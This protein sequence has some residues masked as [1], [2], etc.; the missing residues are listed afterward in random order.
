MLNH[1]SRIIILSSFIA[2]CTAEWKIPDDYVL[3]CEQDADCPGEQTC[4]LESSSCVDPNQPICGNGVTEFGE[5]CDA[6]QY[7][8]D[9][10]TIPAASMT[11][12]NSSCSGAPPYCGDGIIEQD[13]EQCDN[14]ATNSDDYN[15]SLIDLEKCNATC[16]GFRAHCGD[17]VRAESETCDDGIDNVDDY[18]FAANLC[19]TS[20]DG[21]ASYCGDGEVTHNESRYT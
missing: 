12:C 15:D 14:G 16:T 20:C 4:N 17:G 13:I 21:Y 10:Y 7:N 3:E 9:S 8:T 6:G 2:G 19:N 18:G 11:P 5:D 1:I